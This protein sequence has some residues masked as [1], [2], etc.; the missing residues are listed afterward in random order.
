M[1]GGCRR[2]ARMPFWRHAVSGGALVE[3]L[4]RAPLPV[5]RGAAESAVDDLVAAA[6]EAGCTE[7]C[8][9]RSPNGRP[10]RRLLAGALDGS[11]WLRGPADGRSGFRRARRSSP[12]PEA[13][14]DELCAK[15]RARCAR[16]RTATA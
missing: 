1:T 7:A 13:H 5:D 16:R 4:A 14:L 10:L 6:A 15:V 3:R 9:L 12:T 11:P 8:P 2:W